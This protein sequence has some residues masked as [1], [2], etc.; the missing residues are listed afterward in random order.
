MNDLSAYAPA[1]LGVLGGALQ[2][3]RQFNRFPDWATGSI[4][5]LLATGAYFTVHQ[6]GPDWR[7]DVVVGVIG[8]AG[9]TTTVV[10]GTALAATASRVTDI[11][12]RTNSK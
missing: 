8:I 3:A 12:P 9:Y 1:L 5:A 2:W 6:L 11:V 4:A 7:Y 10:G